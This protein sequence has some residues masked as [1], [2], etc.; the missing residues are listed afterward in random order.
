MKE[1]S[2]KDAQIAFQ[3]IITWIIT[4]RKGKIEWQKACHE[5]GIKKRN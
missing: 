3:K 2:L 1:V 5:I 4:F